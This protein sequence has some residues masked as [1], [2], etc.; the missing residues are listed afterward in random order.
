MAAPGRS[1][2]AATAVSLAALVSACDGGA[3]ADDGGALFTCEKETR[4]VDYAPELTRTST[5]GNW[6]AV[7]GVSEPG[8]PVKGT[9]AWTVRVVDGAGTPRDDVTVTARTFMPDH[10]HGSTVKPQVTPMGGGV[11]RVAPLYLYMAGLW[12]VT[13]DIDAPTEPDSVMF[14]ICIPG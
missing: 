8:P 2:L 12:Q 5:S 6:Q 13:L 14:P 4:D 3:P 1:L 9:N 11:Y 10:N 7:L